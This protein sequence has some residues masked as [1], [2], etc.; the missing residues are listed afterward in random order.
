M[1][2]DISQHSAD[3]AQNISTDKIKSFRTSDTLEG[4]NADNF[5]FGG[6]D[7][8]LVIAFISPN[9]SFDA[10][11]KRVKALAGSA[12]VIA[13]TTAG[14]LFCDGADS[15]YCTTPDNWRDVVIQAFSPA[16]FEKVEVFSVPLFSEDIRSG[17]TP[18]PR[19]QRIEKLTRAMDKV[20]PS[21]QINAKD[22]L[23]M[24]F[25]DGLSNSENYFMEAVYRA[26]RFPCLFVGGSAGGKLDF[27]QTQLFDGDRALENHAVMAFIKFAE[28]QR[29]SVMKSQNFNTSSTNFVV[30]DADMDHRT[31]S[32][33]MDLKS[34]K[35]VSLVEAL[36]HALNTTPAGLEAAMTNKTCGVKIGD[37]TF[38]RSISGIDIENGI[39]SF[40]CDIAP[41]DTLYVLEAT[42]FI[43]QTR[44]DISAFLADKPKPEAVLMN[45]CI[46][47]R[48]NNENKLSGATDFWPVPTIGFSTF[49]ELLGVNINQTLVALTFFTDVERD[50]KDDLIDNF[51]IH[52][53][54]FVE[55]FTQRRLNQVK[56]LNQLRTEVVDEIS[57]HLNAS[58]QIDEVVDEVST[59][60][61]VIDT[62]REAIT[63][64]GGQDSNDASSNTARL[65]SK[66]ENVS[67]S[68]SALRQILAIID[69]IT[70]Q[71]NLLALNATIEAARAGEAGRGFSV[72]ASEVKKLATDT[73]STLDQTQSSIAEIEGL[74]SD[75]GEIIEATRTQLAEEGE[76]YKEIVDRVEDVF[77]QSGNIERSLANLSQISSMHREGALS[78][79]ERIEFLQKLEP[80]KAA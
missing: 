11:C 40:Y 3:P 44:R 27:Q 23:A 28:G 55:Y 1:V 61:S 29:F 50:F 64:K 25:I 12:K 48:L 65:A 10:V 63:S 2:D 30:L 60:G 70:G 78:V 4:I 66:F 57:H 75:L 20:K 5:K 49:G 14:E 26:A 42:D 58:S 43:D 74:I 45:D 24:T 22:T 51:P 54:R 31:V 19:D 33:V 7:A 18:M 41:G 36:S 38:V 6:R 77:A 69:N 67:S 47:R 53:G 21:F 8:S 13:S 59:V 16:L 39:V 52:Y 80:E 15:V 32:S 72:V 71:T 76:R 68:L 34:G 37:E 79:Q 17:G 35:T 56:V 62:I 9:A 46:L 73:K